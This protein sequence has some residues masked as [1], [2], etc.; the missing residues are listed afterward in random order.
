MADITIVN[1]VYKQTYNWGAPSCIFG[2]SDIRF[3]SKEQFSQLSSNT[4]WFSGGTCHHSYF[5]KQNKTKLTI[6]EFAFWFTGQPNSSTPPHQ[7]IMEQHLNNTTIHN[8]RQGA[9]LASFS[10]ASF[11]SVS[12][13]RSRQF[14]SCETITICSQGAQTGLEPSCYSYPS[15]PITCLA[16]GCL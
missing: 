12:S 16:I 13:S 10:F 11:A 5:L 2:A 6:R 7:N 15:H 14:L 1:G 4:L 9:S 3:P 8:A